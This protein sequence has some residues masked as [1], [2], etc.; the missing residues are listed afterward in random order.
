M[1][2][3]GVNLYRGNKCRSWKIPEDDDCCS[4]SLHA[5]RAHCAFFVSCRNPDPAIKCIMG[6]ADKDQ[7]QSL[8]MMTGQIRANSSGV[9]KSEFTALN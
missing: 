9:L 8:R 6:G 2:G 4:D 7:V 3:M 1:L 5:G